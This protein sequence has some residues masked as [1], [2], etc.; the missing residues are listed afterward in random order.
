MEIKKITRDTLISELEISV[1]LQYSLINDWNRPQNP[2][3]PA[4]V[5]DFIDVPSHELLRI[6]NLGRKSLTEWR[7]IVWAVENPDSP[8]IEEQRAEYE[9]L[10]NIRATINQI[11]A[12]HRKLATHYSN[13]ADVIAPLV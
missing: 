13:L 7:N 2:K 5:G 4:T 1:R 8:V 11:A 10:K 3:R 6:P 12:T 9:A